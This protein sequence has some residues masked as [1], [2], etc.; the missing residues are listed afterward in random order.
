MP[1]PVPPHSLLCC[2][3]LLMLPWPV[4]VS[5]S[6]SFGFLHLDCS[7]FASQ[8]QAQEALNDDPRGYLIN[9]DVGI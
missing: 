9:A 3:S 5:V 4:V 1:L 8:L 6:A 2:C 7:D